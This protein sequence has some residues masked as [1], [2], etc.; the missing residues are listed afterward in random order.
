MSQ[1]S[2]DELKPFLS[3]V[4]IV[5][6]LFTL[7]FMKMEVRRLGYTVLKETKQ[8]K[9]LKDQQRLQA[10]ELAR[11]TRPDHIRR[12]AMSRLTLSEARNGQIIQL[13]GQR[14]AVPQ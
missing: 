7:A 6:T 9:I 11:I 14:L 4:I 3:L 13:V 5:A 8:H 1:D 12:Y 10:M 2:M